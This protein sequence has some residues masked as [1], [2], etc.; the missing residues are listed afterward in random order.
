MG[1]VVSV[2]SAVRPLLLG[3]RIIYHP[4]SGWDVRVSGVDL[5]VLNEED[6]L[7]IVEDGS[8]GDGR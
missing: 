5:L 6:V 2:G 4:D 7:G 3:R 8:Y 1:D